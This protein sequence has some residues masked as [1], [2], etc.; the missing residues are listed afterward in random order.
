MDATLRPPR[1]LKILVSPVRFRLC[2]L[3]LNSFYFSPA[4]RAMGM[5]APLIFGAFFS[6]LIGVLICV[7]HSG[8]IGAVVIIN[9]TISF[10]AAAVIHEMRRI[11]LDQIKAAERE[12][13]ERVAREL[14]NGAAN[15]RATVRTE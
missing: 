6:W 2:P 13:R 10:A 1:E 14:G 8:L 12:L 15:R 3:S 5:P 4:F 11:E 9:G 7:V